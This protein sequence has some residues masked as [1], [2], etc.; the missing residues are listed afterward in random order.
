[1]DV[2]AQTPRTASSDS[3]LRTIR[4]A[5]QKN[6]S[7]MEEVQDHDS[8]QEETDERETALFIIFYITD[9]MLGDLQ[10]SST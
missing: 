2:L 5:N 1:M 6:V 9:I 8:C 7:V 3:P 10:T 4:R